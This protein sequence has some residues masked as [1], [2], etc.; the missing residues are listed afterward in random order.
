MKHQSPILTI[1]TPAYNAAVYLP[2]TLDSLLSQSFGDF[3]L[4]F[5]DDGSND[6]TPTI[7]QRYAEKDPRVRVIRSPHRG[8]VAARN[9]A[10]SAAHPLSRYFLNHHPDDI[11]LSGK[12]EKQIQYLETHPDIA[13]VGTL[14]EYFNDGNQ[15]LGI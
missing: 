1:F 7:A 11:P 4:I 12:L 8:E 6:E 15:T 2:Q 13:A 5:I 9:K 10:L 14:A 3:E